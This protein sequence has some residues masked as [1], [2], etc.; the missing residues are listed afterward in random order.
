[1]LRDY[2]SMVVFILGLFA[3]GIGVGLCALSAK[4]GGHYEV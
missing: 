2:L 1:M 3:L 4:I